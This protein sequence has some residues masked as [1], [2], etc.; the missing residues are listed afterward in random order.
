[1]EERY[2]VIR[3][4]IERLLSR[5]QPSNEVNKQCENRIHDLGKAGLLTLHTTAGE[6]NAKI[7]SF[8]LER[9]EETKQAD[10]LF[11]AVTSTKLGQTHR[12]ARDSR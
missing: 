1:L 2:P 6:C 5:C 4:S 3:F 8:L 7:I 9:L 12:L 11:K 10:T